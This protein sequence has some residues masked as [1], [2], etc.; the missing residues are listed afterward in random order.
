MIDRSE[1]VEGSESRRPRAEPRR[2][3]AQGL[4]GILGALSLFMWSPRSGLAQGNATALIRQMQARMAALSLTVQ[5]QQ[6]QMTAL[7]QR[8]NTDRAAEQ[9]RL[10]RL[11]LAVKAAAA[12]GDPTALAIRSVNP[13][14]EVENLAAQFE[15]RAH[16]GQSGGSPGGVDASVADLSGSRLSGC[17]LHGAR[18]A[19]AILKGADLTHADLTRAVLQGAILRGAKLQGANMTAADLTGVDLKDAL[20]DNHTHWPS[21]F[22]PQQHGALEVK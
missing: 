3:L 6:Q 20:Y 2:V 22:D 4:V 9:K 17:I 5:Q 14:T 11:R 1:R 8:Q 7:L 21:G 12:A 16:P 15:A 18:L 19:K 13:E 10:E